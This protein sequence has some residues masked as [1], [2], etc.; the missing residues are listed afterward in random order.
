MADILVSVAYALPNEQ[1]VLELDLEAG[2]TIKDAVLKSG[3]LDRFPN[4]DLTQ[5]KV[6]IYGHVEPLSKK[7]VA[8]DRVEIYRAI[9]C[10]PKEVRRQRAKQ[11]KAKKDKKP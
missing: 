2:A 6:G 1:V 5:N 7:L 10:D 11:A 8:K 3:I 4:I 9:T